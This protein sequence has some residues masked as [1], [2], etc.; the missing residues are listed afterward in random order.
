MTRA[1][2]IHPDA[3]AGGWDHLAIEAPPPRVTDD[4][5]GRSV[6]DLHI[7]GRDVFARLVRAMCQNPGADVGTLAA[8]AGCSPRR[9]RQ[10]LGAP[11]WVRARVAAE[12]ISAGQR[13]WIDEID[14]DA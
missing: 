8:A 7:S 2:I 5:R 1:V 10:I 11:G 4:P 9:I 6:R 13:D 12:G 3:S 14:D